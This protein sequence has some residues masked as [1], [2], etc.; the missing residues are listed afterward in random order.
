MSLW[1]YRRPD[2]GLCEVW[3]EMGSRVMA[4]YLKKVVAPPSAMPRRT[5]IFKKPRLARTKQSAEPKWQLVK[6]ALLVRF[7]A[8]PGRK[9]ELAS[10]VRAGLTCVQ[11]EPATASWF[12]IRFGPSTLAIFDAFAEEAER[13][14]HLAGSLAAALE[15]KAAEPLARPPVI[16]K[17]DVLAAKLAGFE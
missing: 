13:Q 15:A 5:R 12:A 9:D 8:K 17:G 3:S 11:Q 4:K 10:C 2:A 14:A 16:E 1:F 7:E 6:V